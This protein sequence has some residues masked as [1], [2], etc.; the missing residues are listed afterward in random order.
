MSDGI[1]YAVILVQAVGKKSTCLCMASIYQ[2]ELNLTNYSD[3]QIRPYVNKLIHGSNY[4]PKGRQYMD[5]NYQKPIFLL[6][7]HGF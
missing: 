6:A 4:M 5:S 1:D 3:L 7:Q 2:A